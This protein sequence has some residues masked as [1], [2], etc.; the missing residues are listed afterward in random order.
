MKVKLNHHSDNDFVKEVRTSGFNSAGLF[1]SYFLYL[2]NGMWR[3]GMRF[4]F[5]SFALVRVGQLIFGSTGAGLGLAN[6]VSIY[7]AFKFN[8]DHY[9]HLLKNGWKVIDENK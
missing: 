9:K 5:L 6:I 1:L 2:F 4:L 8:Q 7:C 3:D